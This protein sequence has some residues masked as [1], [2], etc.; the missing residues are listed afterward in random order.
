MHTLLYSFS[1]RVWIFQPFQKIVIFFTSIQTLVHVALLD[2][3]FRSLSQS[4]F[5]EIITITMGSQT[6]TLCLT[7]AA[8]YSFFGITL[9]ISMR[10]FWGTNSPGFTY[11]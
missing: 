1:S 8:V 4:S 6:D 10:D 7:M 3:K 11:W 5:V 9:A 2:H